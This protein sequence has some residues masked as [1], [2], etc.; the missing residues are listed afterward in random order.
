M[1]GA[2]VVPGFDLSR[3]ECNASVIGSTEGAL[4]KTHL[5]IES[6]L[7]YWRKSLCRQVPLHFEKTVQKGA[8]EAYKY[9]LRENVYDRMVNASEDC[10]KG[11]TSTLPDGLSDLSKC[12]YGTIIKLFLH[13]TVILIHIDLGKSIQICHLPHP[14]HIFSDAIQTN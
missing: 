5:T 12:F 13:I 7:W 1:N 3:G 6:V 10:Y 11:S 2:T 14:I 8:F 4:Y 9:V